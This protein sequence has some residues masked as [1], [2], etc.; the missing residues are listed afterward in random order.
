MGKKYEWRADLRIEPESTLSHGVMPNTQ[1][2]WQ[3]AD[4]DAPGSGSYTYWFRDSNTA[5]QGTFQDL[6]SSRLAVSVTQSWTTSVDSRNYLTVTVITTVNSIVRDDI[7]HPTGYYD[8]NTPGRN[9]TLYKQQ[10]GAVVWS[11]QDNQ[12]ATAHTLSGTISLGSET[13]TLAPGN[14]TNVRPSLYM[15]NQTVGTSSYDDIWLGIQ[16]R[17]PLPLDYRPGATW[18]GTAWKSH[19]RTAGAANIRSA[20]AWNEMR[21]N[22]GGAG[23]D[24]PPFMRHSFDWKN[25]REVG[26]D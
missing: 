14:I 12:V 10:G 26:S 7:R 24:N 9:L 25:M 13:F 18:N 23:S 17:N 16:F 11:A 15:H 2:A 19:N 6:L 3:E 22:D 1:T 20:S 5:W 4:S 8:S 21:T